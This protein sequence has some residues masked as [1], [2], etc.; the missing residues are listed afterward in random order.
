VDPADIDRAIRRRAAFVANP[1]GHRYVE[2]ES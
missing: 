1:A 2:D